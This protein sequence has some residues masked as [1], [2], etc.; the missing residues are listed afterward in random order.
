MDKSL[1]PPIIYHSMNQLVGRENNNW[2][3]NSTQMPVVPESQTQ[4][5][6]WNSWRYY[7]DTS[8][9]S[10]LLKLLLMIFP[11]SVHSPWKPAIYE[12]NERKYYCPASQC[13]F[14]TE[15]YTPLMIYFTFFI[16]MLLRL[17]VDRAFSIESMGS[18]FMTITV[19]L[20]IASTIT[21]LIMNCISEVTIT[22]Q[23]IL[24]IEVM[25]FFMFVY[26]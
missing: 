7:F 6:S 19:I 23:D 11:Y 4:Y 10:V 21:K 12:K 15:L 25:P 8:A 2:L 9:G 3:M 26:I 20:A 16:L 18:S 22:I 17:G 13:I 1:P 5:F 14:S 24:F